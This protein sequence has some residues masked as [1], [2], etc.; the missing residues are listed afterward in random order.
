MY[1]TRKMIEAGRDA[2]QRHPRR[3]LTAADFQNMKEAAGG[4]AFLLA[5]NAFMLGV[6]VGSRITAAEQKK[7]R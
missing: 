5:E 6:A 7:S 1:N 3:E 2:I 4:D